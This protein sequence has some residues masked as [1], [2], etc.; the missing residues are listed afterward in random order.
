M[1]TVLAFLNPQH[2]GFFTAAKFKPEYPGMIVPSVRNRN[3]LNTPPEKQ[4]D[5][6]NINTPVSPAD[7][8]A[9]KSLIDSQIAQTFVLW[10]SRENAYTWVL[11]GLSEMNW[12]SLRFRISEIVARDSNINH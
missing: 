8:N 2:E 10:V 5:D 9:I 4:E 6:S 7:A 1:Y 12:N 3:P 11:R